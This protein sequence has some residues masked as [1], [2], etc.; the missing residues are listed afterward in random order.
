MERLLG[1]WGAQMFFHGRCQGVWPT[2][3]SYDGRRPESF[4]WLL[5]LIRGGDHSHGRVI[6]MDLRTKNKI[7]IRN[8]L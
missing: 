6:L 4:D 3:P 8:I 2:D 5:Q 7:E 1:S